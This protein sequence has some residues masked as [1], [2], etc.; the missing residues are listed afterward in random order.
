MNL[1]Y[2]LSGETED[3]FIADLAV[4]LSTVSLLTKHSKIVL[5]V[6]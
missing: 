3:T 4:G 2:L 5:S 6:F 1:C